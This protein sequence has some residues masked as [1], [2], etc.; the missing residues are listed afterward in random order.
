MKRALDGIGKVGNIFHTRALRHEACAATAA[1]AASAAVA[2]W[3][4]IRAPLHAFFGLAIGA[5]HN[6]H[7]EPLVLTRGRAYRLDPLTQAPL[8]RLPKL[9]MVHDATQI[10]PNSPNPRLGFLATLAKMCTN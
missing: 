4:K 3:W 10:R 8:R 2:Y 1:T 7:E 9:G 5:T 6:V